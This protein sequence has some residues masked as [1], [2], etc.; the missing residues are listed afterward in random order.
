MNLKTEIK[1]RKKTKSTTY[2][3]N[4]Y[5]AKNFKNYA[6][7][8]G[9]KDVGMINK[10]FLEKMKGKIYLRED[11]NHKISVYKN[12]EKVGHVYW[13][14]YLD[15][16]NNTLDT[17]CYEENLY[18]HAGLEKIILNPSETKEKTTHYYIDIEKKKKKTLAIE[19][20]DNMDYVL[21]YPTEELN[22]N[23][24]L[25]LLYG[26]VPTEK[27]KGKIITKE[28]ALKKII[29]SKNYEL[30]FIKFPELQKDINDIE[31]W[32]ELIKQYD[33]KNEFLPEERVILNHVKYINEL[34]KQIK[35]KDNE[36]KKLKK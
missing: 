4:E 8:H 2:R 9:E 35:E 16:W 27:F 3:L 13:N 11:L 32:E 28:E 22:D 33:P 5:L 17:Y 24:I 1:A 31:T 12:D 6:E 14:N 19:T 25:N 29:Q 18:K 30:F 26:I 15:V 36:L 7:L 34:K 20:T 23:E 10:F 21:I